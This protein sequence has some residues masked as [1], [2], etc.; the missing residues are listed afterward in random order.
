MQPAP[1]DVA[2]ARVYDSTGSLPH[3][4][5]LFDEAIESSPAHE[6]ASESHFAPAP[7]PAKN[8]SILR[9]RYNQSSAARNVRTN[10][11]IHLDSACT[12]KTSRQ[13]LT[14]DSVRYADV[15]SA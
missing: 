10:V 13:I 3:A 11:Y 7:A 1:T 15:N 4:N 6:T 9:S 5:P 2:R 14:T 12:D 8:P